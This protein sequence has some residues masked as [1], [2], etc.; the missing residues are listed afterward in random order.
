M[1]RVEGIGALNFLSL[2]DVAVADEGEPLSAECVISLPD[3]DGEPV[4]PDFERTPDDPFLRSVQASGKAWVIVTS[5]AG[6]PSLALDADGFLRHALFDAGPVDVH[7]YCHRPLVVRDVSTTLEDVLPRLNVHR[8]R[9]QD[10]VVD[11]DLV[12]VWGEERRII[13]GA[14]L[15]GRLLRG[16]A[17]V[18]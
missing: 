10:D 13:T 7:R 16:I 17:R 2:D 11:H 12:L 9:A 14:D 1:S 3:H 15:L 5:A 6:E 4:F 18:S 8:E